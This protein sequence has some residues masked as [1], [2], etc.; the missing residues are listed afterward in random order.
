MSWSVVEIPLPESLSEAAV[1]VLHAE[2]ANSA[3][4]EWRG[5]ETYVRGFWNDVPEE[6]A[7]AAASRALQR[8]V[9]AGL[10]EQAPE[11][12]VTTLEDRDWLEGWKQYFPPLEI[13]PKLAIVP[14]WETYT[15]RPE[16]AVV[17][18]DP[19]MAFGTGGH[20]T[21][22]TCLQA[23]AETL[24]PGMAVCD[25]GTGSGILSI[26]AVK[27]GAARVVAVDNDDLAIRVARANARLNEVADAIDFR[28]GDL[29][30]GV[31]GP[32]DLITA[33]ILAPV[34][35]LLVPQLARVLP[36]GGYAITSGYITSQEADIRS[37]LEAAGHTVQARYESNDWVTLVSKILD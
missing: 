13:S 9:D 28:V 15:P 3:A 23:L 18:L 36:A 20:G 30:A 26:A 4:E 29:L 11:F 25:I 37:A 5:G 14:S 1:D 31:D 8:L 32:F 10:L 12:S 17:T 19:G 22:S 35:L 34:I 6:E 27:L 21:T 24:T 7:A 16:Q 2:G 33:N